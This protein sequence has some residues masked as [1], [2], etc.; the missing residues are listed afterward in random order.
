MSCL[1]QSLSIETVLFTVL[2]FAFCREVDDI[3]DRIHSNALHQRDVLDYHN[4][5]LL[6]RLQQ[7]TVKNLASKYSLLYK[8]A[9][10]LQLVALL[11][12]V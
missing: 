7:K 4:Q 12:L 11:L 5:D 10:H 3:L 6:P 1:F 9:H 2:L 8:E